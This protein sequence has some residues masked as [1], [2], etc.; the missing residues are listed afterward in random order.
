M[1]TLIESP[2]PAAT[3]PG[4]RTGRAWAVAGAVAGAAGV[5]AI[6][7]SLK[8]DSVYN[9]DIADD[10]AKQAADLATHK[11][12]M[13]AMHITLMV[14]TV[15]IPVF[16]AGLARRLRTGT[17]AGSLLP[18]VAASGLALT[19]VAGLMGAGLDTEFLFGLGEKGMT[20]EL[21]LVYGHWLS[22]IPWLWVGAGLSGV[23]VAVAA[24]RH[25]AL[26][27]WIGWVSAVLGGITLLFGISPLQYMAGFTGPVWLLVVALGF[28]LGDRK[29]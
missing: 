21:A 8:I 23:A 22:T 4:T 25:R 12:V 9:P 28:T 5:A 13:T 20:D 2:A 1:S 10:P 16:A 26:P 11:G 3:A 15:L 24:V 19:A 14:A 27:R 6:Q 29:A 7:L 18:A 17:P